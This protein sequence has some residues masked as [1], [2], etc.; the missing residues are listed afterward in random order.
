MKAL[1]LHEPW[2]SLIAYG[3][4]EVE[5]RDWYTGYRGPLAIHAANRKPDPTEQ[6]RI[7]FALGH[8]GFELPPLTFGAIVAVCQVVACVP[9]ALLGVASKK[10][11]PN[12]CPARGWELEL[13]FGN[14]DRG[15]WAWIL[16]DVV[17]V[18]PPLA[19]RGFRKLWNLEQ[20]DTATVLERIPVRVPVAGLSTTPAISSPG[21]KAVV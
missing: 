11:K 5:T 14:Y 2:A 7:T 15:R 12:F 16:R 20:N 9:T 13:Q 19:A 21:A 1:T 17:R 6:S 3:W 10:L 8:R 4:K 18:D